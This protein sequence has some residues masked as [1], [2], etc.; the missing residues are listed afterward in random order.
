MELEA[1]AVGSEFALGAGD[2]WLRKRAGIADGNNAGLAGAAAH[3]RHEHGV[4]KRGAARRRIDRKDISAAGQAGPRAESRRE[5]HACECS[6]RSAA[7]AISL[8]P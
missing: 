1:R 4:A 8:T 7:G 5:R 3:R 6:E 2:D